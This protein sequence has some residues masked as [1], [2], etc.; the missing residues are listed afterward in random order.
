MKVIVNLT[1][2]PITLRLADGDH[3]LPS[4]GVARTASTPGT[5]GERDFGFAS[6]VVVAE[7]TTYG[8]VEGLPAPAPGVVYIV[9]AIVLSRCQGRNDVYGPGTGPA[10]GAIRDESGRIVAVTRLIAAPR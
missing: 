1:P 9:S 5:L 4:A 7:A 6:P 10:D 8:E 3:T 2:H